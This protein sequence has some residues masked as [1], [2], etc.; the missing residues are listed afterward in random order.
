MIK[1]ENL[2]KEFIKDGQK[3]EV[4]RGINVNIEKGEIFGI[5]GFSGAGKSSLVRCINLLE[6]PEEGS[7]FI[8]E[9]DLTKLNK[10]ELR[11]QRLQIGMVFQ[12]FNLLK[13]S[14]V[15]DNIA[16]PLRIAKKSNEYIKQKVDEVLQLVEM[17]DK[18]DSYPSMLSGGQKQRV[19]IARAL[20]QN[21]KVLICDEATSALD[22]ITT[23]VILNL[24]KNINKKL[25]ITVIIV[26]HEMEVIKQICNRV[27]VMEKGKIIEIGKVVDVFVNPKTDVSKRFFNTIKIDYDSLEFKQ[28]INYDDGTIINAIFVGEAVTSSIISHMIKEYNTDVAILLGNI[29]NI[30]DTLVGNLLIKIKG[31]KLDIINALAYLEENKVKVEVINNE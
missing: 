22:P 8:D 5:I 10:N 26:T 6:V 30:N 17:I 18:K 29:E 20:V 21:P 19:G 11:I 24:I 31:D 23:K 13:N 4:L 25:D 27:A 9:V 16:F 1:I 7:V 15:Y 28:S 3:M 2:R 12:H 14:T